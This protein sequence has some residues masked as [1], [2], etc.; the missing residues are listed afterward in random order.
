MSQ[1]ALARADAPGFCGESGTNVSKQRVC[2]RG[3]RRINQFRAAPSRSPGSRAKALWAT[4]TRLTRRVALPFPTSSP[5]IKGEGRERIAGGRQCNKSSRVVSSCSS[6]MLTLQSISPGVAP[7]SPPPIDGVIS[8]ALPRLMSGEVSAHLQGTTQSRRALP[9]RLCAVRKTPAERDRAA[10][11]NPRRRRKRSRRSLQG[12][13]A[14]P[15]SRRAPAPPLR[16]RLRWYRLSGAIPYPCSVCGT[17]SALIDR[18]SFEWRPT[19][20]PQTSS[21]CAAGRD[22]GSDERV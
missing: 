4:C 10:A 20:C 19:A 1:H 18:W 15:A 14:A 3:H 21:A 9:I 11:R 12:K 7:G 6:G 2:P 5:L 22:G 13:S 16:A 8:P 17:I